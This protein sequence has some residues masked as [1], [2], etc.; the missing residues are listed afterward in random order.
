M[1]I[2]NAASKKIRDLKAYSAAEMPSGIK[3]DANESAFDIEGKLRKEFA[4]IAFSIRYNRYPGLNYESLRKSLAEQ[5]GV[6]PENILTSNGSDELIGCVM[7]AFTDADDSV[8]YFDPSFEMYRIIALANK[9]NPVALPLDR[10]F[11]VDYKSFSET[12]E[13]TKAKMV[14][15]ATPNNPTG[16][17]CKKATVMKMIKEFPGIVVIDE[18]YCDFSGITYSSA[19]RKHPNVIILRSFSKSHSMAGIRFGYLIA[20]REAAEI[21]NCVRLP[22]NVNIFTTLCAEA[23]LRHG[24]IFAKNNAEIVRERI[25][26]AAALKKIKGIKPFPSAANFILFWAGARAG[27]IHKGLEAKGILIRHFRSGGALEGCLRVSIGRKSE[28][29]RFLKTLNSIMKGL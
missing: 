7:Q 25:R 13:K 14:F 22:Y 16:N 19:V 10:H 9:L 1:N 3:L 5:N 24:K 8:I 20:A 26:V 23:A 12:A 4:S 17:I 18:A 15:L 6:K 27:A 2:K 21:I 29:D 11:E 28:N